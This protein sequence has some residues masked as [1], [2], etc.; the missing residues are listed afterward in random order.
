MCSL[1]CMLR[2]YKF[3]DLQ[4]IGVWFSGLSKVEFDGRLKHV[5]RNRH[6]WVSLKLFFFQL[7]VIQTIFHWYYRYSHCLLSGLNWT[8]FR[9]PLHELWLILIIHITIVQLPFTFPK[10]C[11][12]LT[13]QSF[14]HTGS[15]GRPLQKVFSEY[16]Y[17][18]RWD[19]AEL[20]KRIKYVTLD[21]VLVVI[22]ALTN[23]WHLQGICTGELAR[24]QKGMLGGL[25]VDH[26]CNKVLFIC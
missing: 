20:V 17:S 26:V 18:P 1:E 7:C 6:W 19:A 23:T 10:G 12:Q 25:R 11:P 21:F 16:P 15:T 14:Q 13:L 8:Q 24:I 22:S 4:C 3:N 5:P 9:Y 2:W